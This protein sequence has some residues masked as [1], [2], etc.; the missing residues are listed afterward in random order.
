MKVTCI[1]NG[2]G[3]LDTMILS[4]EGDYIVA[5]YP[6]HVEYHHTRGLGQLLRVYPKAYNLNGCM[7]RSDSGPIGG[8]VRCL[9]GYSAVVILGVERGMDFAV[10]DTDVNA[11]LSFFIPSRGEM[12]LLG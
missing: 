8:N 7:V 4:K 9:D 11:L 12:D 6:D 10:K 1:V 3:R 5:T 2:A